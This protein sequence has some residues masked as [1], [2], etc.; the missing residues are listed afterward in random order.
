MA[1]RSEVEKAIRDTLAAGDKETAAKLATIYE[2]L[3][4]DQP[5]P[6][7]K[8]NPTEG[9]SFGENLAAGVGR[10]AY[11]AARGLGVLASDMLPDSA[12]KALNLPTRADIDEERRLTAPL[13]ETAGGV[14]GNIGGDIGMA[15]IPGGAAIKYGS[16]IP[17]IGKTLSTLG[18]LVT[19]P[20][21][22]TNSAIGGALLAGTQPMGT[23]Q[24]R[25]ETAAYG[26]A[27]GVVAPIVVN[28]TIRALEYGYDHLPIRAA[29][30][31]LSDYFK[32][33]VPESAPG[34]GMTYADRGLDDSF[35]GPPTPRYGNVPG[36]N[37]TVGML[38][39]DPVLLKLEQDARVRSPEAFYNQ[40][41]G[42]T[43]AVYKALES[44]A[45]DDKAANIMQD[46]LNAQTKPIREAA[47][48]SANRDPDFAK[49]LIDYVLD[50]SEEPG[51]RNSSASPLFNQAKRQLSPQDL[52][53][54]DVYKLRQ[55]LADT[56]SLKT[57]APD[58][59]TNAAR[60]NRRLTMDIIN[61]GD[62]AINSSSGGLW[63][64][65]LAKH[66]EGMKPIEEGRSFQNV[67][68]K[69]ENNRTLLGT[70]VKA[71]TPAALRKA[72][73]KETYKNMGKSGYVSTI[74]GQ[75]R[76]L[77]DDAIQ[78]MN[79]L[80]KAKT[81]VIATNG[82]Q[83]A[84]LLSS[85]MQ[86]ALPSGGMMGTLVD[87]LHKAGIRSGNY[88]LDEAMTDPKKLQRLLDQYKKNPPKQRVPF[89]ERSNPLLLPSFGLTSYLT[90]Q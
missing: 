24:S 47:F 14:I 84:P 71:I 13:M 86:S 85:L 73:D 25:A 37:P 22:V 65:Y 39:D 90:Q 60:N 4:E 44:K 78:T 80:E 5:A 51:I 41:V 26:G 21:G 76:S 34:I 15:L 32:G 61:N 2:Q 17:K 42:N 8:V 67:L 88:I 70:D 54:E 87:Y 89:L 75:G 46:E 59:L 6:I 31:K 74:S 35:V 1:T 82:S 16:K 10:S 69:F 52:Q 50:K 66:A 79:D 36:V 19:A 3:P 20:K 57:L 30:K 38:T 55:D 53:A 7:A 64:D 81:G 33:R 23:D 18:E 83:T 11:N 62:D 63:S 43:S 29:V 27:M 12:T 58:E 77:A 28:G 56:L 40:D 9:Q 45:L 49:N 72:V 48:D 68:D